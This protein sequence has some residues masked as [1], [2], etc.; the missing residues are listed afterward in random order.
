MVPENKDP[1][2]TANFA[3]SM[4]IGSVNAS[5]DTKIDIVN[6]IPPSKPTP[7]ICFQFAPSGKVHNFNFVA[8]K[9]IPKIPTD[10]PT[11]S[12]Q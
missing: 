8:I 10:L 7:K 4:S 12:P 3:S 6:P 1:I 5:I 9:D 11:S 2:S